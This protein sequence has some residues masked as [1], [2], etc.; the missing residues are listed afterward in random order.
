MTRKEVAIGALIFSA[1][2]WL[3]TGILVSTLYLLGKFPILWVVVAPLIV[4]GVAYF[5]ISD[6]A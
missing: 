4:Y 2:C 3:G 6:H 5:V 1:Y